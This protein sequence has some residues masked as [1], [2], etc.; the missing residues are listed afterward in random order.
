[1]DTTV[2]FLIA[3]ILIAVAFFFGIRWFIRARINYGGT[4]VITCPETK[5]PADVEV[6]SVH[7]A[8]TSVIGRTDIRLQNCSRWPIKENCGQECLTNLDV[9]SD[10]CLVSS[11]LMK[12]Y[13]GKKCIHCGVAFEELNWTDHQP[14]LRSAAGGLVTWRDISITDVSKVLD[15]YRPVCWN[16]SIAQWFAAEHSDL[17]VY[18][19]WKNDATSRRL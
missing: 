18:R 10:E 15:T 13:R 1:M 19:P 12:W 7:A 8:L 14:A 3:T 4:R 2:G 16:C 6:D 11:V 17:V 9:A 5:R